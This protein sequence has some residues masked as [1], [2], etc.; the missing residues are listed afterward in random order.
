M[1]SISICLAL[2]TDLWKKNCGPNTGYIKPIWKLLCQK[3]NTHQSYHSHEVLTLKI[4]VES[5]IGLKITF[6]ESKGGNPPNPDET[7]APC[8]A[9]GGAEAAQPGGL[10]GGNRQEKY[11]LVWQIAHVDKEATYSAH[12]VSQWI[13]AHRSRSRWRD[14]SCRRCCC[15]HTCS[16][17]PV[18]NGR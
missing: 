9:L 7:W 10:P 18:P 13:L 14:R 6:L 12:S 16:H 8:D 4:A 17:S 2:K 11:F 1:W 15:R 3:P 5:K